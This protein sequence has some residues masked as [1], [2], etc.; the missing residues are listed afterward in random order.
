MV[1]NLTRAGTLKPK[2]LGTPEEG[3]FRQGLVLVSTRECLSDGA[4]ELASERKASK[5]KENTSPLSV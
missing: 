5:Q 4:D 2:Q 1:V 3:R